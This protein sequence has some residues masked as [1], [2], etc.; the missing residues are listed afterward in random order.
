MAHS[1]FKKKLSTLKPSSPISPNLQQIISNP[2]SLIAGN[3]KFN[4]NKNNLLS[5]SDNASTAILINND[6][7]GFRQVVYID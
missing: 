3:T 6:A 4:Y 7:S 5:T 1:N 2:P